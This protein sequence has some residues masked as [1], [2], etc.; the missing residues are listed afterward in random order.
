[1]NK[2]NFVFSRVEMLKTALDSD[3]WSS[4]SI[5]HEDM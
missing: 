4:Y 1:M 2:K 3:Q 5:K